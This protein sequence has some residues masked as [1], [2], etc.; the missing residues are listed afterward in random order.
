MKVVSFKLPEALDRELDGLARRRRS[1]RSAVLREAL[2]AYA[3][4]SRRSVTA[5]AGGLVGALRGPRDLA[6]GR[7]HLAGYG[8]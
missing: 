6:A 2:A 5:A 8:K 4:R 1:T 7:R 3:R